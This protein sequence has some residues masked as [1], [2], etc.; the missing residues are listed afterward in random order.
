MARTPI[1]V[2][3]ERSGMDRIMKVEFGLYSKSNG[4]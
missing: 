4:F 2:S 3:V 1:Q